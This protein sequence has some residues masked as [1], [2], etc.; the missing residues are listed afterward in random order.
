MKRGS[1]TGLGLAIIN[2]G[3][4]VYVKG[5][6]FRDVE[7]KLPFEPDTSTYAAS[8]TKVVFGYT[9]LQLVDKGVIALDTPIAKYLPKPLPEYDNYKD[10]AGDERWRKITPRMLLSHTSGLPNYRGFEDDH[11]LSIHFE[12]G[13]RFAYSGE[14]LGLLQIVIETVTGVRYSQTQTWTILRERLGWTRQRPSRRALERNE[15]AITTWVGR[16]WPR[17]KK[18]PGAG[19]PGSSSR[20]NRGSASSPR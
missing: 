20:T 7:Q 17:I 13:T 11:K 4:V 19:G 10:L 8:F 16:E 5:Y 3:A 18:A 6:G 15:D 9:A 12:P 14:G 2:N 1:V